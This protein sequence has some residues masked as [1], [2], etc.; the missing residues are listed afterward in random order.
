[1]EPSSLRIGKDLVVASV[2]QMAVVRRPAAEVLVTRKAR[3]AAGG[4]IAARLGTIPAK[5]RAVDACPVPE[6]H[7]RLSYSYVYCV[8]PLYTGD[9]CRDMKSGGPCRGKHLGELRSF[10]EI[11]L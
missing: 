7:P 5:P 2:N 1:M 8:K 10:P 9:P 11:T 3:L 6:R 4:I